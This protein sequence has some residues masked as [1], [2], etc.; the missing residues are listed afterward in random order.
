MTPARLKSPKKGPACIAQ[1]IC[2]VKP[3]CRNTSQYT[4]P[5]VADG[6]AGVEMRFQPFQPDPHVR[7]TDRPTDGWTKP[8]IELRFRN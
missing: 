1:K 5:P 7:R 6:W 8:I 2:L 3:L 4:R